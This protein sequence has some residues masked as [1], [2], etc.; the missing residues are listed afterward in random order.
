MSRSY[1]K[2]PHVR[3]RKSRKKKLRVAYNRYIRHTKKEFVNGGAYRQDHYAWCLPEFDYF[4]EYY[5]NVYYPLRRLRRNHESNLKQLANGHRKRDW[6]G[7]PWPD[8]PPL[9]HLE[10]EWKKLYYFK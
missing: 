9:E 4:D 5:S 8:P 6:F 10:R 7:T 2:H 1:K 3:D